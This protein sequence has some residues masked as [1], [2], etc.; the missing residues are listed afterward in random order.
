MHPIDWTHV[1]SYFFASDPPEEELNGS[2]Y[3]A[4]QV[5]TYMCLTY[6]PNQ[7]SLR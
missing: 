3:R 4:N 7:L 1:V 5:G 2:G 6:T